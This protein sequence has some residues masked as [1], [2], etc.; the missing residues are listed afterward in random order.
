MIP[1][2]VL[3]QIRRMYPNPKSYTMHGLYV[4][5]GIKYVQNTLK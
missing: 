5:T 1:I 2:S 3:M 4:P